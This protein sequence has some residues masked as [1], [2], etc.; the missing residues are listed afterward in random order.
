MT[1]LI[2]VIGGVDVDLLERGTVEQVR[3]RTRKILTACAPSKGYILGSGTGITTASQEMEL[4]QNDHW[5]NADM[6]SSR[7]R[8]SMAL[9]HQEPDRIPLDVGGSVVTGMH[10]SAVYRLRQAL[11]LDSPGIPVKVIDPYQMLGE[12]KPDLIEALNVDVVSL[13]GIKTIFG[14]K[15]EGWQP[16]ITFD[17]TPVLVP[18][19]FNTEPE[20]NGD[21]LMYP[22]GDKTVLPSGRMPHGGWY[23]DT[24]I[25]Q[26]PINKDDLNVEDNLEEFGPISE[27]ELEHF[28][29]QTERLYSETDK[30]ILANF[31]GTAFGDIA[32]VPAPWLKDP[33][34]IRDVEEWYVSTVTRHDYIYEVF[35]RQCEIALVN[36][37]RIYQAVGDRVTAV[38]VTGTDFGMQTG[39]FISPKT[40]RQLYQPFHRRVNDWIHQHTTWKTFIHSCGS[41]TALIEDF[42]AAGFDILNPVQCSAAN[43]DPCELKHKFGHRI[44]FWGGGVDTQHTLPFGTPDEVR[45]QVG[46][47]ISIFGTGG[48]FVFNTIHNVQPQTPVENLLAMFETLRQHGCCPP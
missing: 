46:E 15:N 23:F 8:V 9:N 5:R 10:V 27:E 30:A 12:I 11:G 45:S 39:P 4:R 36:L 33:R 37:D 40:Y 6:M 13:T 47:R 24:I 3:A 29:R 34:G 41:V 31:G 43:M 18:E 14:F 22:E 1:G 44:V 25:R 35:D 38:F 20:P 7:E 26:P 19:G 17:G 32:L 28:A 2:A 21:L 48:G 42:I 16:W